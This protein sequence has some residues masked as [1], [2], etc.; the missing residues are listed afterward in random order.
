MA[1]DYQ[2]AS[3][4]AAKAAQTGDSIERTVVAEQLMSQQD[5]ARFLDPQMLT[6]PHYFNRLFTGKI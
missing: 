1:F 5:A 3:R 6:A 2:T 4:I